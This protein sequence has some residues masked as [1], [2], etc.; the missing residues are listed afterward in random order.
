MKTYLFKSERLGFRNWLSED[1]PKMTVISSDPEVM[2]YF[3]A[4]ATPEQTALFIERMQ[5]M[6]NEKGYCYFAVDELETGVLIGFIGLYYQEF[7]SSFTPAV[8][9]GWRL[10]TEFWGKGYATEG[11][12]RCLEYAFSVLQLTDIISTAPLVNK[13][14]IRVMEKIG[15]QKMM[16]FKHPRLKGNDHLEN[17]ACYTIS[18]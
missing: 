1:I 3:P 8:D 16:E 13:P 4:I 7:D 14:S 10:A 18:V 15:M 9:I 11:A 6:L 5:D 12:R 17:C 2:R